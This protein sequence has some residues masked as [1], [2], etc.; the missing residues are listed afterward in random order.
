VRHYKEEKALF[1][2][3]GFIVSFLAVIA[4]IGL[5]YI[6]LEGRKINE[7]GIVEYFEK[8]LQADLR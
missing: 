5:S 4:R 7:K 6:G 2:Q 1:R 3:Q 8:K